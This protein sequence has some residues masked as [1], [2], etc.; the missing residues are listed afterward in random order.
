[1]GKALKIVIALVF[2]LIIFI[3]LTIGGSIGQ[4]L[5]EKTP[6]TDYSMTM[7]RKI[8]GK[9]M[10]NTFS[11]RDKSLIINTPR[12]DRHFFAENKYLMIY[13]SR[14]GYV[15]YLKYFNIFILAEYSGNIH[16]FTG[17]EVHWKH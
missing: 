15:A 6:P 13:K 12:G 14:R 9:N 1:M 4:V 17:C 11:I 16:T 2:L 3:I 5:S 7:C 10:I 8:D